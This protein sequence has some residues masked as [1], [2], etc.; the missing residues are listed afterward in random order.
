MWKKKYFTEKKKTPPL[1]EQVAQLKS[2]LEQIH[3]KT[4]QTIDTEA[5]HAQQMGYAKESEIGVGHQCIIQVLCRG[6]FSLLEFPRTSNRKSSWYSRDPSSDRTS[7]IASNNGY[8]SMSWN[9]ENSFQWNG[10][11]L[12]I[13][14]SYAIKLKMSVA[15]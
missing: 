7:Q 4:V 1:E 9:A 15:H 13:F 5:K 10:N 14:F 12:N 3:R 11:L 2:D 6:E 8:Q